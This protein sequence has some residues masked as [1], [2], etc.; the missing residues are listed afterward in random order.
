MA[1]THVFHC[2]AGTLEQ[3]IGILLMV[4][5]IFLNSR[6][7]FKT[8]RIMTLLIGN[9]HVFCITCIIGLDGG[10]QFYFNPAIMAPLFFYSPKEYRKIALYLLFTMSLV[11]LAQVT[12]PSQ[13]PM[14]NPSKLLITVF[15]YSSVFGSLIAVFL[16]VFHFYNESNHFET[17]LEV[18]NKQ[19]QCLSETDTLTQLPNRRSF[20]NTIE[21]EWERA[22][23]SK[24]ILSV[25]MM[26]LDFFKLFNDSYG[27]QKGDDCLVQ[28]ANAIKASIRESMDFPARFGG[29]EFIL[30]ISNTDTD[31]DKAYEITER[32]R[33]EILS[34]GIRHIQDIPR[35]VVS[36]SFGIASCVPDKH[37][38]YQDLINMADQALYSAK[39]NGRNR[40]EIYQPANNKEVQKSS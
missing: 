40:I 23:R 25:I 17:S 4:F 21:Q 37:L 2:F 32:I 5:I 33:K 15:Y 28:V 10:T 35:H 8:S 39:R 19:L 9:L 24:T 36:S 3:L 31:V 20:L 6:F 18:V 11:L 38:N 12:I 13:Q 14:F 27:H 30:L 7:F 1:L 16:F 22:I 34:L 29:E 26:D